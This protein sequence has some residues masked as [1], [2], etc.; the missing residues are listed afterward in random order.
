M[1]PAPEADFTNTAPAYVGCALI[2]NQNIGDE[3][4]V[5]IIQPFAQSYEEAVGK[6]YLGLM[7]DYPEDE[8]FN[9]VKFKVRPDVVYLPTP[10][11]APM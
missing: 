10:T 2:A 7:A 5:T 11:P 8:G 1:A 9:I 4:L 6:S 3:F